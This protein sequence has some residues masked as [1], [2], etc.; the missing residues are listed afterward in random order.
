MIIVQRSARPRHPCCRR[1]AQR[2]NSSSPS[3]RAVSE[4]KA[5]EGRVVINSRIAP[6]RLS[7]NDIQQP[8]PGRRDVELGSPLAVGDDNRN[9]FLIL[10]EAGQF[11]CCA[12]QSSTLVKDVQRQVARGAQCVGIAVKNDFQLQANRL[13][14]KRLVRSRRPA[15]LDERLGAAAIPLASR[16]VGR[17]SPTAVGNNRRQSFIPGVIVETNRRQF[18]M[19]VVGLHAHYVETRG[20]KPRRQ[21]ERA[22]GPKSFPK[23]LALAAEKVAQEEDPVMVAPA[24]TRGAM[25]DLK[26]NRDGLA[27]LNREALRLD[28]EIVCEGGR[29]DQRHRHNDNTQLHGTST[30]FAIHYLGA[31]MLRVPEPI[32]SPYIATWSTAAK[33]L[34]PSIRVAGKR[35]GGFAVLVLASFFSTA[36]MAHDGTG[37]AGGFMSGFLHPLSGLDHALAMVAV[38]LWGAI[39]RRPLIIA[40]PTIFPVMMTVGAATAMAGLP[41]PPVE[42]GIA[43]SVLTLGLLILFAVRAPVVIACAIVAAFAY[44]HGFAHGTELPSAADPVGYST[45]FV[46]STGLLHVTGITLGMLKSL[47]AGAVALRGAGCAMA[48]VG[49]W[50]VAGALGS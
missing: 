19:S 13:C 14:R 48:V 23:I 37:L 32:E 29:S 50:F 34:P 45:G 15:D 20:N 12:S 7:P 25:S 31:A 17:C 10:L 22:S 5:R 41:A 39:L 6:D 2:D 16:L 4:C 43:L 33:S 36:A 24:L 30:S 47:P 3:P 38:G 49:L 9:G 26:S 40:L 27:G 44:F 28:P 21:I 42:L 35:G 8:V 46:L 18:R 1:A 11:D